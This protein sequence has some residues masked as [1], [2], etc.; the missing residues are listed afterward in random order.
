MPFCHTFPANQPENR[1]WVDK[2]TQAC[3]KIARVL[4]AI[5]GVRTALL[6]RLGAGTVLSVHQVRETPAKREHAS[7]HA[8][9]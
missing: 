8:L 9:P 6:S 1:T 7:D 2:H 3:P 4:Q 5:P